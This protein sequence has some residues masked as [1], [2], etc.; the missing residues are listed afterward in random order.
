LGYVGLALGALA[1]VVALVGHM[2]GFQMGSDRQ[3]RNTQTR[4][5]G[6][7][8]VQ[9]A[10]AAP[11]AQ[12]TVQPDAAT[13]PNTQRR[14][15]SRTQQEQDRPRD[16]KGGDART[17]EQGFDRE[18]DGFFGPLAWIGNLAQG[19]FAVL[20]ILLGL[21]LLRRHR[22]N[23]GSGSQPYGDVTPPEDEPRLVSTPPQPPKTDYI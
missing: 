17:G 2:G 15:G 13:A 16:A 23:S 1:L 12:P 9:P 21:M 18:H 4:D 20:A 7:Q 8:A 11:Q 14:H 6:A 5:N 19:G 3:G 10:Q 22:G